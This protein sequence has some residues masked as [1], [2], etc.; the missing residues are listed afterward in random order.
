MWG[1]IETMTLTDTTAKPI[2]IQNSS[3][4][5]AYLGWPAPKSDGRKM[6]GRHDGRAV[7]GHQLGRPGKHPPGR[8]SGRSRQGR[9]GYTPN[10]RYARGRSD[11]SEN[12]VRVSDRLSTFQTVAFRRRTM[13]T[14]VPARETLPMESAR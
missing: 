12:Q 7:G 11:S 10:S 9:A 4:R 6:L 3:L 5:T 2:R 8:P 14:M 1:A 13:D